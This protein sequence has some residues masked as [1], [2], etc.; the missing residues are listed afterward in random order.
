LDN[1]NY[2]LLIYALT[3]TTTAAINNLFAGL[4]FDWDITDGNDDFTAYDSIGNF[5]Y[6]YHIG[7]NPNT[8]VATALVSSDNYGFWAINNL[9]GDGGFGLYDGFNDSEKWQALSSAIGKPQAGA[10]DVSH[11]VSGGPYSIQPDETIQVAFVVAAGFNIDALRMAVA[12]SRNNYIQIPTSVTDSENKFPNEFYLSQNYPNPFNPS[13]RIQYQVSRTSNVLI[14]IFDVL[15]NEIATLVNEYK[16]S[17][18]YA[19][20]FSAAETKFGVSLPS[21]V[22]F[23]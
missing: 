19:V 6:C 23:Y 7:G 20:D 21:C 1:Q 2:I 14:K 16:P 13:T 15:G 10:G 11:V 18:S 5:G 22:Y 4:F 12:N 17:G 8:W 9:G 3:N